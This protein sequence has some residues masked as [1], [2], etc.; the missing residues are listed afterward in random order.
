MMLALSVI[1]VLRDDIEVP[2]SRWGRRRVSHLENALRRL[3][4]I[5]CDIHAVG[6]TIYDA[7][8]YDWYN[9]PPNAS[10][11]QNTP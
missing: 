3:G 1:F 8:W 5:Q 6:I 4:A 11:P 2:F 9:A 10:C 7:R